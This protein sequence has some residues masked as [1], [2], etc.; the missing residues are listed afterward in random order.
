MARLG[1]GDGF[2]LQ[3]S[4]GA[5]E[6]PFQKASPN[7]P[8]NAL[9]VFQDFSP[10]HHLHCPQLPTILPPLALHSGLVIRSHFPLRQHMTTKGSS[11]RT[12][13]PAIMKLASASNSKTFLML[14]PFR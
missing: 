11:A 8:S 5:A 13:E 3:A 9:G 2:L 1:G 14:F 6:K 7:I 12:S 4:P 10:A